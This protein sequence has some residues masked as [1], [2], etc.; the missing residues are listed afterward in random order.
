[1]KQLVKKL[2]ILLEKN[3]K[4][5]VDILFFGSYAKGR[6]FPKDIDIAVL[7]NGVNRSSF[8][9]EILSLVSHADVQFI[10]LQDYDKSLW[11]TLLQ[12]GFSLKHQKYLYQL[13]HVQPSVLYTYSLLSLRPSQKVMFARAIKQFKGIERLSNHVVLV[14][15]SI[16][17]QFTDF[18]KHWNIDI[19]T[20]EYGLIPLL[21]KGDI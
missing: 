4:E 12:E 20:R 11:L 9:K 17:S 10:S 19:D 7:E 18:L 5:V 6:L 14:P 8:K 13:Y 1:M 3:K 15:I 2:K 21:R 16:S